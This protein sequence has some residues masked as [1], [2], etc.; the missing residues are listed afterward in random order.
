MAFNPA[1]M[2]RIAANLDE[3][4]KNL[5]EAKSQIEATTQ[6][7]QRMAASF[8]GDKL[9]Q[10]AGNM[11]AAIQKVGGTSALTAA[12][13][14]RANAVFEK[15]TEKLTALGKT[16]AAAMYAELAAQ[17]KAVIPPTEQATKATQSWAAVLGGDLKTQ[18]A[19]TMAG[20]ISAQAI[21]G[22]VSGA[23]RAFTGFIT[24]SVESY[25][26][27]ESAQR[28]LTAALTAAG[29]AAPATIKQY[30]DLAATFQRTT[31]YSDDLINEMQALL[32]QVGGVMPNEMEGA[33]KAATNLASGLGID[34][35][36]ATML[37]G[38][39]FEGETGTLK[40]YGI[41][42]DEAKLKAEGLPAV[43]DAINSKF[44]GQAA[45]EMETTAG[46]LKQLA[47]EWDN[48]KE[49]VGGAII[50]DPL[51]RAFLEMVV[52]SAKR[53]ADALA[54]Q[55][56]ELTA[57][58]REQVKATEA[59]KNFH[60]ENDD[61]FTQALLS[62][63]PALGTMRRE[64]DEL[65]Q[66][67][68]DA[69]EEADALKKAIAA[70]PTAKSSVP[71]APGALPIPPGTIESF[72]KAEKA[73]KELEKSQ[74]AAAAAAVA[75]A[76]AIKAG[77]DELTGRGAIAAM[78]RYAA[79][80][81]VA[82]GVS[83]VTAAGLEKLA[84]A[85]RLALQATVPLT[86]AARALAMELMKIGALEPPLVASNDALVASLQKLGK[87]AQEDTSLLKM[88]ADD[89]IK[90]MTVASIEGGRAFEQMLKGLGKVPDE[91][92]PVV[93]AGGDIGDAF[94]AAGQMIGRFADQSTAAMA[95]SVALSATA[96]VAAKNYAGAVMSI[97]SAV[98]SY[99]DAQAAAERARVARNAADRA[100]AI[101][102]KNSLMD[103]YGGMKD[104]DALGRLLGVNLAKALEPLTK[105][106]RQLPF[107]VEA[108]QG[109]SEQ[110]AQELANLFKS[111]EG[112]AGLAS[113]QLLRVLDQ[114]E[115]V[116]ETASIANEFILS[117]AQ[118]A[119]AGL[120]ALMSGLAA[121][122]AA[123]QRK[124]LQERIDAATD[125]TE[126]ELKAFEEEGNAIVGIFVRTQQ[127]AH[128]LSSAVVGAFG[129]MIARGVSFRDA[130][131]AVQPSLEILRGELQR[132]GF[133]G[134]A[135]FRQL[136]E[137]SRIA[138]DSIMGPLVDAI[139]GAR[140]ALTGLHN[141]G[142]MNQDMFAAIAGSAT[143]AYDAIIAQGGNGTSALMM[144][145]PTL[146]TIWKLQQDFGYE[147]DAA[148][149]AIIDQGLAAGIVGAQ[150]L[151][152]AEK[153]TA[154]QEKLV[155]IM[156]ELL[157]F[158]QRM[159]PAAANAGGKV[160]EE[161]G[162]VGA[163]A[164]TATGGIQ[165][166]NKAL[167]DVGKKLDDKPFDD[168]VNGSDDLE[169]S[170][171]DA[172]Q[173]LFDAGKIGT[174]SMES[175]EESAIDASKRIDLL[176]SSGDFLY[177][178]FGEQDFAS[179]IDA[180]T[181]AA[182]RARDAVGKIYADLGTPGAASYAFTEASQSDTRV[183]AT[184]SFGVLG[185]SYA[186]S[187]SSGAWDARTLQELRAIRNELANHQPDVVVV[188][189][190]PAESWESF[191]ARLSQQLPRRVSQSS[192][193]RQAWQRAVQGGA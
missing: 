7:M 53:S 127:Q 188:P 177:E 117:N 124:A 83:N 192:T 132:T 93:K 9:I 22:A 162:K 161:L 68:K 20:F 5:G 121:S 92:A 34:L 155:I 71:T 30:N 61:F 108:L 105:P 88:L 35:R 176:K 182:E 15:A 84:A 160:V 142:L 14:A 139:S 187:S 10:Q 102:I 33:L 87:V 146:Q 181:K 147:V 19:A 145:Q 28:K 111:V 77:A 144:M 44:G 60:F 110:F 104:I 78:E 190:G 89:G 90:T 65:R 24:S 29:Q 55:T 64:V 141:S 59:V 131:D 158:F 143:Q 138:N 36:Q 133:D 189:L 39:A 118:D 69:Q 165:G 114:L 91:A 37:V 86:P 42:I 2:V 72:I 178:T 168:A 150:Q 51:V 107:D 113:D 31:V 47:N 112:N 4:K 6:G 97:F 99:M 130:L 54:D 41:V 40:R 125:A 63:I 163:A 129:E 119:A 74:K 185:P 180:I 70:I 193:L 94:E 17:T 96:M 123:A 109:V 103:V 11:A 16:E 122:S 152:D 26:A 25:M 116:K 164:Q 67:Y 128:G 82:G 56:K 157:E 21:I 62:Y 151:T 76:K 120:N 3:F 98:A 100:S 79:E 183:P 18:F 172:K 45:A 46:K 1:M 66:S 126:E 186:P 49:A 38:K 75:L 159:L 106:G 134:G 140:M 23:W 170:A 32:T 153:Q 85:T 13:M 148:T 95:A 50:N 156:G 191:E 81:K 27:A 8:S 137:M 136:D 175:I 169:E 167:D 43:L 48:V 135:A 166:V 115:T 179:P 171:G 184:R 58:E 52:E 154:A 173:A 101:D 12:E 174:G 149:Q 80:V 57:L 73:Q